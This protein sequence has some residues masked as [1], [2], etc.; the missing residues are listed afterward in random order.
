MD[1]HW[2]SEFS[3]FNQPYPGPSPSPAEPLPAQ[4]KRAPEEDPEIAVRVGGRRNGEEIFF[5]GW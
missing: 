5:L 2:L 4:R 1:Y 3:P